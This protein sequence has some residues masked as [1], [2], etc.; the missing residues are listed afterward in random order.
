MPPIELV[1]VSISAVAVIV[2]L[3]SA[4][5]SYR[6]VKRQNEWQDRQNEWQER[7]LHLEEA[8]AR[9]RSAAAQ[10]AKLRSVLD[11]SGRFPALLLLNDG[12]AE[13]RNISVKIDGTPILEHALVLSGQKEVRQLGPGGKLAICSA[14]YGVSSTRSGRDRMGGRSR[15]GSEL[16]FR[17]V[18]DLGFG[19]VRHLSPVLV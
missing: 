10:S 18:T 3:W 13:A 9:N 7:L 2:S 8:E 12:I 1:A 4:V 6:S 19:W 11:R 5:Q 14:D 17:P 16:E 15:V